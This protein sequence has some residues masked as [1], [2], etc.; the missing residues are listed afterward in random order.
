MALVGGELEPPAICRKRY[1]SSVPR[2]KGETLI[3]LL[4]LFSPGMMSSVINTNI[5]QT[6]HRGEVL[7][8]PS[9][10]NDA[11]CCLWR[12]ALILFTPRVTSPTHTHPFSLTADKT[13][14][15]HGCSHC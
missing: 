6:L 15:L 11:C 4:L 3:F 10:S 5:Q 2:T 9:I 1:I 14:H 13:S 12:F 7:A 8:L